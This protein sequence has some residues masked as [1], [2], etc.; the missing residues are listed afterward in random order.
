MAYTWILMC[1]VSCMGFYYRLIIRHHTHRI[2]YAMQLDV[3]LCH[4][5]VLIRS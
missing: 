1:S 4:F 5:V 3:P 2:K